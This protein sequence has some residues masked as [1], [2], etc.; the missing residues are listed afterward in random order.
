MGIAVVAAAVYSIWRVRN[1]A[2]WDGIVVIS[3]KTIQEIKFCVK[4]RIKQLMNDKVN[5]S[6]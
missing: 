2:H 6:V 5:D 4:E 3:S 1:S